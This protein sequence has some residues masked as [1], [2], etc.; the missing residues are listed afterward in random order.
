MSKHE[1]IEE[2]IYD[3]FL[4]R[5]GKVEHVESYSNSTQF[6]IMF[7]NDYSIIVKEQSRKH[8][9]VRI[10]HGIGEVTRN[11]FKDERKARKVKR[12]IVESLISR[13]ENE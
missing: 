8:A 7:P 1:V 13:L 6:L 11:Y 9:S 2:K 4:S 10:Y 5:V 3:V 12:D